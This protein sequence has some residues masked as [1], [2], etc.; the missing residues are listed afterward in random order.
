L[1][2]LHRL[3]AAAAAAACFAGAAHATP[4]STDVTDL[5]Y[6]PDES[7][8][9]L[10][11]YQQQGTVFAVLFVYG[12]DNQPTW[13]V[14]SSLLP[15]EVNGN[16]AFS[17]ALY[18][19]NGPY[20]GGAFN[21]AGVGVRQ[22]GTATFTL[23]SL[24]NGNFSYAVDGVNVT[25]G[26]T[27]QTWAT[28]NMSGRYLGG[29]SG[30]YSACAGL[31]GTRDEAGTVTV[32]QG[33]SGATVSV[34]TAT[35]TCTYNGAYAQSGHYGLLS[36]SYSCSNGRTGS[37]SAFALDSQIG[38]LAGRIDTVGSDGCR[39]SGRLGGIRAS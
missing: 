23:T 5:W 24:T 18:R 7:G 31:D 16:L 30:T 21:P 34:A 20:F 38:S 25:K 11:L 3:A 29:Q 19:T 22:V 1:N 33:G 32:S 28:N 2:K 13:Y 39:Y 9:G 27:R 6:N 12:T 14:A 8:W 35:A 17:G 10:S 36:G 15:G 37:F 26:I 4:F